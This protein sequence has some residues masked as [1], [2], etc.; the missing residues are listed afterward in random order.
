[1]EGS[2]MVATA[3]VW[4]PFPEAARFVSDLLDAA[5]EG[6]PSLDRL[7]RRM[8]SET[9]TKLVDWVDHLAV[10]RDAI[11]ES[12]L[13]ALG[14]APRARGPHPE[15]AW[16]HGGAMLPPIAVGA[17]ERRVCI[18][19]DS[20][21]AFL[22]AHG[23]MADGRIDGPPGS[24]LR[25]AKAFDENGVATWAVERHGADGFDPPETS[26]ALRAAAAQHY[27]ALLARPRMVDGADLEAVGPLFD[28]CIARVRDAQQAIGEGWAL[29]L[30]FRA[31]RE[32]WQ[33][34]N[35]AARVQKAR[36]DA[37]GLGWANHD[38]HTYR[39][40]RHCFHRLVQLME[41]V[42]LRCRERF[43]AGADAGWGAQVLEHE[44]HRLVVFAD[45][46]LSPEEVAH[47]FAH[48][49]LPAREA[50]G[51]VGLWCALHGESALGAGMHHLECQYE[52]DA[53]REQLAEVGVRSMEPF[54]ELP[55]LRQAFTDGERW[56][57]SERRAARLLELGAISED[58]ARRFAAEGALGSHLE[59][60]ERRDGYRGFN[61]EGISHIIRRTDPR[62]V[63][64]R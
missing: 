17:V 54:T 1:M 49:E 3:N 19:V 40:S 51:T 28:E 37:L 56:P 23:V 24:P 7:A 6:S 26:M 63:A 27:E 35:H 60:L 52:F 53:A 14:F 38:H 46:D 30:F 61:Q 41:A 11:D 2:R 13:A 10:P 36:Q 64:A 58:D 9:G 32:H 18:A 12:K 25:R 59:I 5:R 34:R 31:E 15:G 29:A 62:S 8:L 20:V 22:L 33:S 44:T 50:F 45:V 55:V 16:V 48:A 39:S 21:P 4:Q 57:V 47:D 43:Y 42:G